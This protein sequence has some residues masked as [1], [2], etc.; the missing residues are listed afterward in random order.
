MG[1]AQSY[2]RDKDGRYFV[3]HKACMLTDDRVSCLPVEILA[4]DQTNSFYRIRNPSLAARSVTDSVLHTPD[5]RFLFYSKAMLQDSESFVNAVLKPLSYLSNNPTADAADSKTQE[6]IAS[7]S[8]P[9]DFCLHIDPCD[10]HLKP[11][12][13]KAAANSAAETQSTACTLIQDNS[14]LL[15]T[16]RS[17]TAL[18]QQ[19]SLAVLL[20]A[21][22][23]TA[24]L[25]LATVVL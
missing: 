2:A 16:R 6:D 9:A 22:L 14:H 12:C 21:L 7:A 15:R 11:F 1:N 23:L 20:A 19:H 25:L 8:V 10:T 5:R 18:L 24:Y 13:C 3:M 17:P 4:N